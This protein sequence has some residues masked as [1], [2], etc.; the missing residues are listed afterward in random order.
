MGSG[1][2]YWQ[3]RI[4]KDRLVGS[5]FDRIVEIQSIIGRRYSALQYQTIKTHRGKYPQRKPDLTIT[6]C[7]FTIPIE[8]DGGIHGSND[9]ISETKKTKTRNDDYIRE[10]YLP[11][12]LN[13]EQL[14]ALKISEETFI[15]T[16]I[17]VLEPIFRTMKRLQLEKIK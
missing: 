9:E 11:I 14:K 2:K 8:L 5:D 12:I 7:G 13:H 6:I 17:V 10:G 1:K 4:N 16:A 3:H 15:K